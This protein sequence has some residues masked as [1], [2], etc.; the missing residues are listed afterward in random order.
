MIPAVC[1]FLM[2]ACGCNKVAAL[3]ML[4]LN[5]F[6]NGAVV[7]SHLVNPQDLAP[8]FAGTV[9]AFMNFVGGTIP[10]YAVMPIQSQIVKAFVSTCF[11]FK[12]SRPTLLF[13][14][15]LHKVVAWQ[16]PRG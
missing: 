6:L 13:Y 3:A 12:K 9:Y 5:Q 7:V 4:M 16:L 15:L 8:N 2:R 11:Y 10:G 14:R 1:F